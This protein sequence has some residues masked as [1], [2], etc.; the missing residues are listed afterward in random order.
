MRLAERYILLTTS[1]AAPN[2][3]AHSSSTFWNR[4]HSRCRR[5]PS[6]QRTRCRMAERRGTSP[7]K[8]G[9]AVGA[10]A[11]LGLLVVGLVGAGLQLR[12]GA[13]DAAAR[14]E[15]RAVALGELPRGDVASLQRVLARSGVG[16]RVIA[17]NGRIVAEAGPARLWARGAAPWSGRLAYAGVGGS[18]LEAGAVEGRRPAGSGRTLALREALPRAQTSVSRTTALTI[19]AIALVLGLI[20]GALAWWATRRRLAETRRLAVAAEAAAAGRPARLEPPARGDWR[21]LGGA[22]DAAGVRVGELQAGADREL[23]V[24]TAAVEPLPVAVMG[25]GPGGA[26]LRNVALERMIGDLR[27]PDREALERCIGEVLG[28]EGAA[29]ERVTL[30]DGRVLEVDGWAVPGGRLASVCERTEQERL[31]ALRRQ[32]SGGAARQLRAPLDE[33][34][35]RGAEV[36]QQV[37]A[38]AAPAMQALLGAAD[39]LDRV[40]SMLLRGTGHEARRPPRREA[41]GV[42]GFL[43]GLAHEWDRALR[44][45]AI[46]VELELA[47]DLPDVR[48]DPALAEEILTELIDNAAKFTPRGGTVRLIAC[49]AGPERL[50]IEVRDTGPG[51]RPEDAPL[52]AERFYRGR[53]AASI[54]G[55]GL[56]LGVAAALAERLG[57]TLVVEPGAGGIARLELPAAATPDP[58]ALTAAVSALAAAL[59]CAAH[60]AAGA[61]SPRAAAGAA[62]VPPARARRR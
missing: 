53:D 25:R 15:R 55:A 21:R 35:A 33:I 20:A 45:R 41:L 16:A 18:A 10:A 13:A 36:Y 8:R 19:A 54:P 52:V 58:V 37:P 29:A 32:L 30:S 22:I 31:A 24:L 38:P 56:G 60:R 47:P 4:N 9:A 2:P 7:L 11:T 1:P 12:S 57:G 34:R 43:W 17:R 44:T 50:A 42:A 40:V 5:W 62:G 59:T 49:T 14:L 61:A 48:T 26:P 51:I 39:R 23:G 3:Q 46:R 6:M 27:P 28:G